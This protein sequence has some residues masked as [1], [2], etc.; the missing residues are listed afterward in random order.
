MLWLFKCNVAI[1]RLYITNVQHTPTRPHN[2]HLTAACVSA[3]M[4][5][6]N[7]R[8]ERIRT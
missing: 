1:T 7:V 8:L 6:N 5:I 2:N 4:E 3:S